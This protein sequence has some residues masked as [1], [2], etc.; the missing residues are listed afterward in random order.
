MSEVAQAKDILEPV[1]PCRMTHVRVENVKGISLVEVDVNE[2]GLTV[3]GGKNDQGKSSFL[4]AICMA[5][6]GKSMFP[7]D[8]I[9]EGE[10]LAEVIV[11]LTGGVQLMPWPCTV[12]RTIEREEDGTAITT[13]LEI[14]SEDGDKAPGPQ[15]ILDSIVHGLGFD[16]L[17]F[18]QKSPKDQANLLRDLVGLDFSELDAQRERLYHERTV[19]GR[20]HKVIDGKIKGTP[21]PHDVPQE[22]ISIAELADEYRK[23]SEYNQ[24]IQANLRALQATR[25]RMEVIRMELQKLQAEFQELQKNEE[26]LVHQPT[27][28]VD[29]TKIRDK[30]ARAE[31]ANR[32]FAEQQALLELY[33]QRKA[34]EAEGKALTKQIEAIDKAKQKMAREA[35]WPIE[36]LGFGGDGIVYNGVPFVQLSSSEQLEVAVAIAMKLNPSFPFAIVRAG[37][38]LDDGS[39]AALAE[40][41]KKYNG[42]AFV[43]RVSTGDECH[44]V[45]EAGRRVK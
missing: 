16:P 26:K 23:A 45:F 17:G 22:P 30:M 12:R 7:P 35:Q 27:D 11:N 24:S 3:L 28:E 32:K 18:I 34:K 33:G 29:T 41:V 38:L 31:E 1:D 44:I 20:Q 8:P 36:G 9:R 2:E 39:L 40:I 15:G 10:L 37:S 13:K 25:Q 42:Q 5:L 43:E 19:I 6:G 21:I 4:D 14:I